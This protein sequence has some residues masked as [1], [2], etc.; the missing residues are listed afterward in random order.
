MK[1][2]LDTALFVSLSIIG[3]AAFL[4]PFIIPAITRGGAEHL[5]AWWIILLLLLLPLGALLFLQLGRGGIGPKTIA[6]IGVLGATMVALR[7]P[8]FIFGF[9]MLFIVVFLSG[10]AF[11]PRFGFLLGAIGMFASALFLG[12]IGP[13]LPFQ[14]V[15]AGWAGMGAGLLPHGHSWTV[16]IG[17]LAIYGFLTAFLY[18]AIMNLYFWPFT[19][20]ETAV[21]WIPSGSLSQNLQHYATFYVT[22]SFGWDVWGA[23][24]NTVLIL[25]L[26][27]PALGALDRAAKR[28]KVDITPTFV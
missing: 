12:G 2:R 24:G 25:V 14:M 3:L 17:W 20:M 6:L 7:L 23:L 18:G 28:M 26:G 8:G 1:G 10:N 5:P 9:N 19:S 15:A 16:R 13:W 4:W 11:G 27:R 22:T 21:A